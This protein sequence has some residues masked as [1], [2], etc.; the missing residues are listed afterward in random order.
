MSY[1]VQSIPS[2][3]P[4]SETPG[5][6]YSPRGA[7]KEFIYCHD[8]EVIIH[9]PAETGKTLA[10]CWLLHLTAMKYSGVQLAIVRKTQKSVYGSVLQ[11][12]ARVI[13]DSPVKI[14]GGEKPEEYI[15]PNGSIIWIGGMDNPDKVL[16]SERA[17]IYCNQVEEFALHDWEL[18]TT[19]T[20]G[21]GSDYPFPRLIG[22]ANPAGAFHWIMQRTSLT[23]IQAHHTDNPT[24]FTLEGEM[25]EQ[26]RKT[27]QR[28]DALTGVNKKR[29]RFGIWATAE[30]AVFD[31][32]DR[33]IHVVDLSERK[34]I[35]WVLMMDE[36]YT[37]PAVILLV[38]I[39]SDGRWYVARE[40]YKTQQLEEDVV[41]EAKKWVQEKN[42]KSV[43]VDA[44]AAG[45]IAALRKKQ[46][47]AKKAKGKILE[48]ILAIQDRLK[49]QGDGKPRLFISP[50]CI[51]T[52]NEFESHVWKPEKDEPIDENNHSIASLRYGHDGE[53]HNKPAGAWGKRPKG[54]K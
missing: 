45:L 48:G 12:F 1:V 22:D 44:A 34:F 21:R 15:Y 30:G 50:D 4:Y 8:P 11:T 3:T 49:V 10:A 39:D 38:G 23:L 53:L 43:Y 35:R 42:I 52:I 41:I 25:T 31:K 19:R 37:H 9:G 29:L 18:M 47:N 40:F 28:L 26:G 27:F 7:C 51:E 2:T 6:D 24:L 17:I 54:Q 16:S 13:K 20:T 46:I 32:F 33:E 14:Y 36:G 5:L